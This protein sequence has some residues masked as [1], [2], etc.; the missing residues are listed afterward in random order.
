MQ[1]EDTEPEPYISEKQMA[2][3]GDILLLCTDGVTDMIT[4]REIEGILGN[5]IIQNKAEV[6]I[7]KAIENGGKDNATALVVE[8]KD[9]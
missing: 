5:K 8:V 2:Q 1:E 6:I 4:E 3:D 9:D 7:E